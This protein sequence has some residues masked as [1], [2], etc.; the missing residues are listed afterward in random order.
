MIILPTD[1]LDNKR[2]EIERF[3][4]GKN[5]WEYLPPHIKKVV[6]DNLENIGFLSNNPDNINGIIRNC[7]YIEYSSAD[8]LNQD[9]ADIGEWGVVNITPTRELLIR[10]GTS[11]WIPSKTGIRLSIMPKEIKEY[12]VFCLENKTE[13]NFMNSLMGGDIV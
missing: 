8:D 2:R 9:I 10:N 7:L 1:N 5:R 12:T 6:L 3:L 13:Q 4:K 11:E